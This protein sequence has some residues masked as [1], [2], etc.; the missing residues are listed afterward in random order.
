MAF[1]YK[2]LGL[3]E[4]L[5]ELRDLPA[6]LTAE[7]E[8]IV[9]DSAET[10]AAQARSAYPAPTA[11][12][13]GVTLRD[14]VKVETVDAGPLG[15]ASRVR[16]TAPHARMYEY[17]TAVRSTSQGWNRGASPAHHVLV[18]IAVRERRTM[19]RTLADL[20]ERRGATVAGL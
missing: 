7:A 4:F 2:T 1:V 17:G 5:R 13:R 8:T 14:G 20:L 9:M 6:D 15:T 11:A 10:V 19:Y 3:D 12:S 16:N 18:P